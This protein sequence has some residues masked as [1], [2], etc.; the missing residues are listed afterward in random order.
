[1][2]DDVNNPPMKTTSPTPSKTTTALAT[3]VNVNGPPTN[4][5]TNTH[6]GSHRRHSQQQCPCRWP[7]YAKLCHICELPSL[8]LTVSKIS[9]A[10]STL[11]PTCLTPLKPQNAS[12]LD[13]APVIW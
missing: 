11:R 1:M 7:N 2:I 4:S 12:L 5:T 8:H 9:T 13:T 6:V 3:S 10:Y